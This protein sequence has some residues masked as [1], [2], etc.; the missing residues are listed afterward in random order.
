MNHAKEL[1]PL[2]EAAQALAQTVGDLLFR[3]ESGVWSGT[4]LYRG[5]LKHNAKTD[6]AL[7]AKMAPIDGFFARRSPAA[8]EELAVARPPP[9]L[10]GQSRPKQSGRRP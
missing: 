7:A 10:P 4:L 5:M 8:R 6:T 3:A 9:P 1:R 2:Y